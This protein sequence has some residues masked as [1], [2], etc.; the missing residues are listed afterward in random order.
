MRPTP[1]SALRWARVAF[2]ALATQAGSG[3]CVPGTRFETAIGNGNPDFRMGF[4]N[5]FRWKSLSLLTTIDWQQGG[6]VINL[7]GYLFDL[8]GNTV[9]YTNPCNFDG[10]RPG[11]TLGQYRLRVYP[12]RTSK[13]WIEKATFVKLRE[14]ALAWQVPSSLL[15]KT[16]MGVQAANISLSGRNLLRFTDY[17]GMDPEVHN[18][19]ST[20]IRTNVDVGP[21][22]PSRSFW[23]SINVR[24]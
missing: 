4:S 2:S 18:F 12:G 13:T 24:F 16:R 21:Y 11:E 8:S 17:S 9:D 5:D 1:A 7:L 23:L 3:R 14:V 20:A 15:Q 22:P 10:C 6:S 19:G